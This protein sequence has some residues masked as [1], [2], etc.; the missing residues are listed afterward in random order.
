MRISQ[1]F[2]SIFEITSFKAWIE[3]IENKIK[4]L[5]NNHSQDMCII[6]FI[7]SAGHW[8]KLIVS[9]S[10]TKG[11]QRF[12]FP[13]SLANLREQVIKMKFTN[14]FTRRTSTRCHI[15]K[16]F[17]ITKCGKP[18]FQAKQMVIQSTF[19]IITWNNWNLA[20]KTIR[21][22]NAA[23]FTHSMVISKGFLP[24]EW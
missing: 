14:L 16:Y 5:I 8:T 9:E 18:L 15:Q 6:R 19:V 12:I 2:S 7:H 13:C 1:F 23:Q 10:I 22:A 3:R 17:C 21:I 4:F 20:G 24:R 11:Q